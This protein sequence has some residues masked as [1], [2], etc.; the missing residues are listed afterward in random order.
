MIETKGTVSSVGRLS[1]LSWWIRGRT[2]MAGQVVGCRKLNISWKPVILCLDY[3][4]HPFICISKGRFPKLSD[5]GRAWG[6]WSSERVHFLHKGR[7]L[8]SL[9]K[10]PV[11]IFS[12]P[13]ALSPKAMVHDNNKRWGCVVFLC[14]VA[15]NHQQS[16]TELCWFSLFCVESIVL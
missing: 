8:Q 15:V 10:S 2:S 4:I 11:L 12:R 16:Q 1:W 7:K 6:I 9:K 14:N 3:S 5:K 13:E